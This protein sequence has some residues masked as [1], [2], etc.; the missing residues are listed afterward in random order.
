MPRLNSL[1]DAVCGVGGGG[2]TSVNGTVPTALVGVTSGDWDW[3]TTTTIAGKAD[4]GG[5]YE[6]Y[7]LLLPAGSLVQI[8]DGESSYFWS[9]GSVWTA[10]AAT[11]PGVQSSVAALESALAGVGA[12]AFDG[13]SVLVASFASDFGLNVYNSTGVLQNQ[14]SVTIFPVN[15]TIRL[16]GTV[17]SYPTADLAWHLRDRATNALLPFAQRTSTQ[18]WL[19]PVTVGSTVYVLERD[20]VTPGE[21]L[22]IRQATQ[23]QGYVIT[24]DGLKYNPDVVWLSGTTVR[25]AYSTGAAELPSELV[26]HDI[27]LANGAHTKATIVAG[28]PVWVAQSNVTVASL[29]AAAVAGSG[30]PQIAALYQ[31][32]LVAP[33]NKLRIDDKWYRALINDL[34]GIGQVNLNDATGV[35][36]QDHG[37]TGT[38][39]GLADASVHV[40]PA[41]AI[42]GDG[43]TLTPLAVRVDGV[44][45]LINASNELEATAGAGGSGSGFPGLPGED[46]ELSMIPGPQGPQGPIGATGA[47]GPAGGPMGPPGVDGE[48]AELLIIPGPQGNTGAAGATGAMVLIEEQTPSGTGVVTFSSLG[49]HT[50]LQ[51]KYSARGTDAN[52]TVNINLTFNG[53]TGANYD[54]Q[55]LRGIGA[56]A[57]AGEAFAGSNALIVQMPGSTATANYA[58][59]GTIDVFD[60]RGTTFQKAAIG[61]CTFR[62]GTTSGSLVMI[63]F[64]IGWRS[65]AAITSMTLTAGAGNYVA[66]AKFSLYG[67][68]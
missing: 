51:V 26:I 9:G 27:N 17:L 31:Q 37:G 54:R 16:R 29:P 53:D 22:T 6:L 64:G 44:T 12:V 18:T 58:G 48:D 30:G 5:G 1:G 43:M 56:S 13:W 40:D 61:V 57:S 52:T 24:N 32:P 14:V 20:E 34:R 33:S 21:M 65:A 46:G 25:V 19:V 2:T 63:Q 55:F 38:T 68:T 62:V 23:A 39:T 3:L 50:H 67:I 10:Y 42:D 7:K 36:D 59:A 45:V 15:G 66:G 4:T 28:A 47:A 41:G 11:F 49:S 60:Y 8:G 35:L